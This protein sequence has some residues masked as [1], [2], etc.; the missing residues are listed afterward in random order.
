[1]NVLITMGIIVLEVL[2]S[3]KYVYFELPWEVL[4]S[5]QNTS[6]S[7]VRLSEATDNGDML[8]KMG[9]RGSRGG[10][11]MVA[12][13]CGGKMVWW[14]GGVVARWCGDMVGKMGRRGREGE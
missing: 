1:M 6:G 11:G 3:G 13:W 5:I 2:S 14:Q 8:D 12:R 4:I 10:G 9:R 7:H